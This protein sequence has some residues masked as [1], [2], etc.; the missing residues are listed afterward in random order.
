MF[1]GFWHWNWLKPAKN[2]DSVVDLRLA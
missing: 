2:K 1:A